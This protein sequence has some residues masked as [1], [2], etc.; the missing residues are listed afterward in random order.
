M[1]TNVVLVG[2]PAAG[3]STLG[4]RLAKRLSLHFVDT[5][6]LI[7]AREGRRLQEILDDVGTAAFRRLEEEITLSLASERTLV[8][9]G[10]SVVYSV[11]SME[12]LRTL[13]RVVYLHL[14]LAEWQRR[15][16]D[17]D[18]RGVVRAPEQSLESLYAEREP[19]YRRWADRVVEVST[20]DP[21]E[22]VRQLAL[23][24]S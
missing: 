12:H 21:E 14:T 20:L 24:A 19:L 15:L 5:D 13:G 10:G 3:K 17:L 1:R 2:L 6:L 4:V 11:P 7:Q 18:T 8:A 16:R 9:T 23:A 22:A